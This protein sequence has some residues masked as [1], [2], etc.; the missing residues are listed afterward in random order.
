MAANTNASTGMI[1]SLSLASLLFVV[2]FVLTVIFYSKSVRLERELLEAS[3]RRAEAIQQAHDR[4]DELAREAGRGKGVVDLLLERSDALNNFLVGTSQSTPDQVRSALE[5]LLPSGVGTVR[6]GLSQMRNRLNALETDVT[7]LNTAL[8]AA[9]NALAAKE[10]ELANIRDEFNR[11]RG[12]LQAEVEDFGTRAVSRLENLEEARAENERRV[13]RI[14][15]ETAKTVASL[16]ATLRERDDRVRILENQVDQLRG[17]RATTTLRPND[18]AALVDGKVVSVNNAANEVF[19]SLGRRNNIVLGMTFEVYNNA[20]A[21]RP[22]EAGDYPPGKATIEIVRVDEG[23]SVGRLVRQSRGNPVVT[24]DVIANAL[25]DP[26][27]KYKFVVFGLFDTD[28]DGTPT[29]N[30]ADAVRGLISEWGGVVVPE[31]T[32]DTDFVVLGVRPVIGPEPPA[33]APTPVITAYL[34]RREEQQRYDELFD[35]ARKT[36]I[37]V[38]NLNRLYTLTGLSERR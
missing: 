13:A 2:F 31:I 25:Y 18:E 6:Q 38:L 29:I 22:N 21:I 36:A 27:K 3:D 34:D 28:G 30:E 35:A 7:Q 1:V 20:S 26:A 5:P 12:T 24:G 23:T 33:N 9:Q 15:E 10:R 37:P 17:A 16:E 4:F 14:R 19:L 11:A 32:G 8:N